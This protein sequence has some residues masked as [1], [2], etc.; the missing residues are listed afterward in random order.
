MITI[1][2]LKNPFDHS[3]KVIH[4]C[5]YS[6]GKKAFEYVQ[7]Y[8]MGL[9]DF[10]VSIN[11]ELTEDPKTQAVNSGD[12][13]AVCP[14]VGKSG[15]DWF[16]TIFSIALTAWIGSTGVFAKGLQT[17]KFWQGVAAGAVSAIGGALINHWFPPA[18]PDKIEAKS[19]YN[20]GNAQ[21]Q[22][23]QG[24]ALAVTYGTMR[25]AGQV[26]AQHIIS[27]EENQYMS[28]LLCG[29]EGPID[30]I[31]DIRIND[32][33]I[34][35]YK[36]VTVETR[37]GSNDQTAITN[38]NDI[39]DDQALAYELDIEKADN[40]KPPTEDNGDAEKIDNT[41]AM[42]QTEGNAVEGLE[43]TLSFPGGLYHV[44]DN[45]NFGNA[46]VTVALEFR[47]AGEPNW[48]PFTTATITAAKNT[49]FFRTYRKDH[50]AAGQYEVRAKCTAKSGTST[51]DSTRVFWTQLSSIMYDDFARPGKVLV[52]IKALATNQLSGGMPAITWL[53]TREKV[54]VWNAETS[55]YEQKAANNPAWAAYD[56]IHRCRQIKN[57]HTGELEFIVQ[58]VPASRAVYQD[59]V[60]WAAFCDDRKLT[61]NYIYDTANDLWT[62]LQKPEGV[63]RGKV[64]LRGT[65]FGCVCD[66]P[67][68]PVQLFTVGNILTDK[69][70]ET[71]VSMKDRA[72]AI[73]VSFPNKDKAY[74]K[75]VI[76]VYSDDYDGSTE[77]N[78]TQITLDGAT[79]IEQA[80]REAKYRL[81]LN[82][83]L[84][85]TVEH[86]ADIDAIACQINDVV[87][88]AHDVPQ[89]GYS[90]RLLDATA[91]TLQLD[92]EVTLEANKSYAVAL[93][94]T[95]PAAATPQEVQ[96][97]ETVGV[98]G[99]SQKTVTST[100]TLRS[101]LANVP[102]KWDLYSFG[103]T[104][105][106][107]KPFRVLNISR[108]QDLK[109]KITC[110]EYIE[111]IYNE[112]SDI[113]QIQYS[114]IDPTPEVSGLSVAEETY[115]Q[116]DGT[117]VSN[118]N[119]SW[120]ISRTNEISGYKVLYSSDDG[121]TWT[122]WCSGLKALSTSIVGVKT[123]T[124]YLV[125]VCTINILNTVSTGMLASV[126]VTGKDHPPSNVV[127]LVAAIE[128]T[129][130]TKV[131]LS[132]PAVED[133][134]LAGYRIREGTAIVENLAQI[135]TYTYSATKSRAH[136]F[137][138]VAVDN[139]GNESVTPAVATVQVKVEPA[140]VKN[141]VVGQRSSDRSYL[142]MSWEAVADT[143]LSHYEIRVGTNDDWDSA[144]VIA[145]Q[146]KATS[147]SYQLTSEG[148][149]Y[150]FIKAVNSGGYHSL[151]A[152]QTALQVNLKPDAVDNLSASQSTKDKS[153]IILTWDAVSGD[154]IAGYKVTVGSNTY[155]TKE[156]TYSY[157][158]KENI[159]YTFIVQSLN[160]AGYYSKPSNC[161]IN[162]TISA[163]DVT[164]FSISQSATDRTKVNLTWDAPTDLDVSYYI[165]KQGTTWET[166]DLLGSRVTGTTFSAMVTTETE[167][168]FLIK[169]VTLAGNESQYPT[170]VSGIFNLN[171]GPV[172]NIILTQSPQDKSLLNISWTGILE[173]DLA[174][175]DVRMGNSW[176]DAMPIITTKET[177]CTVSLGASGTR[178][179][180][181]KTMNVAGFYSEET[182]ATLYCIVEPATV[183]NLRVYQNGEYVELYWDKGVEARISFTKS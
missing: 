164:G 58:G 76:I 6:P 105:K 169:A 10:V 78:I 80:Y 182:A 12:W 109:R 44:K 165:I 73:E 157:E 172:T 113:P 27:E 166:A 122:E 112:A 146:L 143:S 22:S 1:T 25:T 19:S 120:N 41:W 102:V 90:G 43:V 24:N 175:Y 72:N 4:T 124:T 155:F 183:A 32:N 115:R 134:D 88:L 158:A 118:L 35:Y 85:R 108:D 178:K 20:W 9:D 33:P 174:Y 83:Y 117:M 69:F 26:L 8:I 162:V 142:D 65:R 45:G 54:W 114:A 3:E 177:Y 126:Y 170:K 23:G 48:S 16:R 68:E 11:G 55:R 63:G 150:F 148:Y 14:V 121:T 34:S 147:Y 30:S 13:L 181:I 7:P 152:G 131:I 46:S 138:V 123:A 18:K 53:Q 103:E 74:E 56:M 149:M 31:S 28:I 136:A 127:S 139:S 59:F 119:V 141:F 38:F 176:E 160:T 79:T 99:V 173:S 17:M 51:R 137:S 156:L 29:G 40:T 168:T 159:T 107:V 93:Q 52:G 89:W 62:Q 15:R 154:D 2:I 71:F 77:P 129:D 70:K 106:A 125:K 98:Q 5:E 135:T 161:S 81:R 49:A 42:Q 39:Y 133:I 47:Q 180:L 110:L 163:M 97:I 96:Q 104:T 100:L 151:L 101:P 144:T 94:I 50:L 128:P 66:A 153:I 36:G 60:R 132:W 86:S 64:I 145:N 37:L 111:E 75:E 57:I 171:P 179:I 140:D 87:L 92:R 61:F 21:A 116:K 82:Q 91:T 167:Q 130:A 67:G 95:N 84:S